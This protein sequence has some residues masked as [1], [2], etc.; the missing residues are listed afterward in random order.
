M[1][2]PNPRQILFLDIETVPQQPAFEKLDPH[3]QE[4]WTNKTRWQREQANSAPEEFYE[5]RAGILAEFGKVVCVSCGYFHQASSPEAASDSG[6]TFRMK[7]FAQDDEAALLRDFASMLEALDRD[8]KLCAHNGKEFD[9]PYLGRRMLIQGIKLP[10]PLDISGLKPWEVPHIDTLELWKL[11]DRKNFT[12]LQ[13]LAAVFGIPTPKDDI[14]GSQV[15]EVYWQEQDLER[16]VRYCEK[17]VLTL[18]QVFLHIKN[19]AGDIS[20]QTHHL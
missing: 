7:S 12:S 16:I 5:Q 11:G 14:D 9:F 10:H 6:W 3:W 4:L 13:L 8:Y 1:N 20:F 17:D 18:A 19:W 2:S 15:S